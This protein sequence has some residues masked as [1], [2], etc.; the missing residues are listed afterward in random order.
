MT[1]D[2]N[3]QESEVVRSESRVNANDVLLYHD[4]LDTRNSQWQKLTYL[5]PSKTRQVSDVDVSYYPYVRFSYV[6]H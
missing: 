2:K 6:A 4:V 5:A 3:F 1:S